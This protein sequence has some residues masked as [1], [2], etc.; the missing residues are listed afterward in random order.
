MRVTDFFRQQLQVQVVADMVSFGVLPERN[1]FS[2]SS[3][4]QR[5]WFK[6]RPIRLN[7]VSKFIDTDM[8]LLSEVILHLVSLMF[9]QIIS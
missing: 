4:S 8:L 9:T 5:V 7:R 3:R 6:C 1:I 2:S